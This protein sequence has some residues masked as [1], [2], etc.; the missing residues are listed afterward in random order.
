MKIFAG[1]FCKY[2]ALITVS[3]CKLNNSIGDHSGQSGQGGSALG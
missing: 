2:F 3:T 1:G